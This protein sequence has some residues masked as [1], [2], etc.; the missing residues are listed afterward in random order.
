MAARPSGAL[1]RRTVLAAG[2]VSLAFAPP[3][4]LLAQSA[5]VDTASAASDSAAVVAGK[6]WLEANKLT[7][8][9]AFEEALRNL[10]PTAPGTPDQWIAARALFQS[11]EL[12]AASDTGAGTAELLLFDPDLERYLLATV[13]VRPDD[14]GKVAGVRISP[15]DRVPE[16]V[17]P[18]P[19]LSPSEWV[20][21]VQTRAEDRAAKGRFDGAVLVARDGDVLFQQAYGLADAA[22]RQ[23]NTVET[24]FR[25]GSMGKMFTA[26][27]IMQLIEAGKIDP[28]APIGRRRRCCSFCRV[29]TAKSTASS[30]TPPGPSSVISHRAGAASRPSVTMC[31]ST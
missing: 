19:A 24:Q 28:S 27:A 7:D 18:A 22:A 30:R 6:A 14:P 25:F 21:A 29:A 15:T 5:S 31:I 3:A 17:A 16:G 20:A 26:V 13:T 8:D 2:F 9:A 11:L 12:K 23:P 10:W 4:A 1:C